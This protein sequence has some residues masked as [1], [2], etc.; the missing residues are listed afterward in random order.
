[1]GYPH[2]KEINLTAATVVN[3]RQG[4]QMNLKSKTVK[5][6]INMFVEEVIECMKYNRNME[7]KC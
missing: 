1:M 2:L 5:D 7:E 4:E 3:P 6:I